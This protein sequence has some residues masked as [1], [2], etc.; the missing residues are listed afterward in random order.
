MAPLS[1]NLAS[2]SS[3]SSSSTALQASAKRA[4]R[5]SPSQSHE[6][7]FGRCLHV[8]GQASHGIIGYQL[9]LSA[10]FEVCSQ[11]QDA[12]WAHSSTPSC[13][14]SVRTR[15]TTS[16]I[17]WRYTPATSRARVADIVAAEAVSP[18]LCGFGECERPA[19]YKGPTKP[20]RVFATFPASCFRPTQRVGIRHSRVVMPNCRQVHVG[21]FIAADVPQL[22]IWSDA[23]GGHA[24]IV[25]A[26]INLRR[27]CMSWAR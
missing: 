18:L 13:T 19:P 20:W 24:P 16:S 22:C 15:V 21:R 7:A 25:I 8:E 27:R 9:V 5:R 17:M 14:N 26:A 3:R 6:G 1:T 23:P 11:S 10:R 4:G 2:H 12:A